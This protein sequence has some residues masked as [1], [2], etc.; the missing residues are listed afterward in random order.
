MQ[1]ALSVSR[2]PHRSRPRHRANPHASTNPQAST[3]Q[4]PKAD[5]PTPP[6]VSSPGEIA[7]DRTLGFAQIRACAAGLVATA[8][9][10]APARPRLSQRQR[11]SAP[12]APAPAIPLPRQ[13]P[14]R[15]ARRTTGSPRLSGSHAA[16][17][18][19][20]PS[21]YRFPDGIGRPSGQERSSHLGHARDRNAR[22]RITRR[23]PVRRS[24]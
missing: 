1:I 21:R 18:R 22:K 19:R 11:S 24:L 15:R 9:V 17:G 12:P 23:S 14:S 8:F 6:L 10:L 2:E 13:Q 5:R 7:G 4:D 3:L 20:H 16:G